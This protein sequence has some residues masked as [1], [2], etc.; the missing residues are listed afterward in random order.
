MERGVTQ[1]VHIR[2]FFRRSTVPQNVTHFEACLQTTTIVFI[3]IFFVFRTGGYGE[4]IGALY[5][6]P[7]LNTKQLSSHMHLAHETDTARTGCF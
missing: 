7:R 6:E 3:G 2:F 5:H 4:I 1:T